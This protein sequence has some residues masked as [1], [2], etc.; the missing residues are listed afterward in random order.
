MNRTCYYLILT[1]FLSNSC[2]KED[3]V[4]NFPATV[5]FDITGRLLEGKRIT[6]I[7]TDNKGN[8]CIASDKELYY[9]NNNEQ[10]VF[11]LDFPIL[12]LAIAPDETVWI[13]TNGGG[14]GHLSGR[15]F[16]WYT[17]ANAGLP[18]DYIR[19][20]EIG[21]DG[22]VWLSCSAFKLGGLGIFDGDKFEFLTPEN[23]PLNQNIISD[24]EIDEDG[25][26]YIATSG[27]VGKS[28]IYRISG[29][30]WDC[31]GDEN[32]TFYWVW[33]FTI[34]PSGIIYL[35][36]DF[37]LSSSS[38]NKNKLYEFRDN[39]WQK[40]ETTDIPGTNFYA[41]VRA[42]KRNYC[43]LAV[44]G[45]NSPFLIVYNGDYWQNS[46]AGLFPDDFITAIEVDSNNNI[47]VGT[48]A[49]GVFILNQ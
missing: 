49:N 36:E 12:D 13:G 7:A 18:R 43:W 26:I 4:N 20:V 22:N 3:L 47:W 48:W 34:A 42:D 44:N 33:S 16:T 10:K 39:K 31:L 23:S 17:K 1:L 40:I 21:K 30:T 38:Y 24:L 46:P 9:R 29:K 6:S 45:D 19:N 41:P 25:N 35:V 27:T 28:N 14:L 15:K 8:I 2:S 37:S 11:N 5:N 32:G